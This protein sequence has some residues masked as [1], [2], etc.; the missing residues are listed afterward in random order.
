MRTRV[1]TDGDDAVPAPADGA[2]ERV[3][4]VGAGIAGLTAANALRTAGVDCVVVE[5][6][7]RIG[8]RLHTVD[9]DGHAADLGGSWVHHPGHNVLADWVEFAQVPWIADP[10]GAF[11]AGY[12][13]GERRPLTPDELD[14]AGYAALEPVAAI[15]R[16]DAAA[17]RPDR[18]AATV[19]DE[20]L[21]GIPEPERTRRWQIMAALIE[22]DGA[23]LLDDISARWAFST[24]ALVGDVVDNVPIGGYRRVLAPLAAGSDIRLS[25]P[26][27]RIAQ[28]ADGVEVSGDGWSEAGSH[29][30]VTLPL[31]VLQ[32]GSVEFDPPLPAAR[33]DVIAGTGFGSMEKVVLAFEE[34]F[35]RARGIQHAV[36]LP[37]DRTQASTWMWDFGLTPTM[38]ILIAQSGTA[39]AWHDPRGWALEQLTALC[40]GDI[41]EP[42]GL[43]ATDWLHDAYARGSY[44]HI[45]PGRSDAD[46]DILAQPVG[47][48]LFA[49][50]HTSRAR[51]G[52]ADGALS[53][54]LREAR[55]LLRTP[56]IELSAP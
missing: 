12:D 42:T 37:A 22:Q 56:H 9:V 41:P 1:F 40:G 34:P 10:S 48:I 26:V 25:A 36:V 52:Y 15:V 29:A 53:S 3:V 20:H 30:I 46:I 5:A 6:R 23:G 35:W 31:G 55:R 19:I 7:D 2:P 17:G 13:L 4:V 44:T 27:R 38:M 14:A 8:G 18:S 24:T 51:L 21:A 47:R 54:A 49:G 43:A 45:R 28:T 33:R 32:S 39:A 50:E 11:F 16:A